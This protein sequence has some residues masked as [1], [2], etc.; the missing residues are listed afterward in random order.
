MKLLVRRKEKTS[1][2]GLETRPS[3]PILQIKGRLSASID[4]LDSNLLMKEVTDM[5]ADMWGL[6]PGRTKRFMHRFTLSR[7]IDAD[8]IQA[9]IENGVVHLVLP[10]KETHR[11]RRIDVK[12][13]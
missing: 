6:E 12:A 4:S 2:G 10:K 13:A 9:R 3:A 8:A 1:P 7:E 5:F 11:R